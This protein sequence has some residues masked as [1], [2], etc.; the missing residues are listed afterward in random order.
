MCK[1]VC[2]IY[3]INPFNAYTDLVH[4]SLNTLMK[5]R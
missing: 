1:Y 2:D 3:L 5:L 4:R